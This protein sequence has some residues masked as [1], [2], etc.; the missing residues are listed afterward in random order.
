MTPWYLEKTLLHPTAIIHPEAKL[1]E[2]VKVGAYSIIGPDVQLGAGSIVHSHVVIDGVVKGGERNEFFP[3]CSIGAAPQ[4]LSY[5]GEP[6][7]VIIGSDNIFR[8]YVS[9]HRGT[10]KDEQKTVI[11]DKCLMMAHVHLG[12][13]V[14]V[15]SRC[16][17]ANSTNLAGHVRIGDF[18]IIGGGTNISQFVRLGIGSYIGGASGVDRDIPP[19]CTAYGNRI[20]LKGINIIGLRRQGHSRESISEIVDFFRTMESTPLSPRSFVDDQELISD[21]KNNKVIENV[22]Q[23]IRESEVGIAPFMS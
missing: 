20:K 2:S 1:H 13:D 10:L 5:K 21:Y 12:H 17:F 23:F 18:T 8:E 14:H 16:I 11:G 22:I 15:G 4:D 19:F 9:I 3:F 7:E 6:T